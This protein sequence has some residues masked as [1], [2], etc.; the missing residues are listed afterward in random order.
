ME[1]AQKELK[2]ARSLYK[3]KQYTGAEMACRHAIQL[4]GPSLVSR[5]A[6]RLLGMTLIRQNSFD[7][8]IKAVQTNWQ[9]PM[10]MEDDAVLLLAAARSHAKDPYDLGLLRLQA[11]WAPQLTDRF[12]DLIAMPYP[13]PGVEDYRYGEFWALLV[14]ATEPKNDPDEALEDLTQAQRLF[15]RNAVLDYLLG[16]EYLRHKQS[17]K[18]KAA[19]QRAATN[20]KGRLHDLALD[21]LK[22]TA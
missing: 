10:P 5:P 7:E 22:K 3:Q 11:D 2:D 8:A 19:L 20:S 16:K 17:D 15:G 12:G 14:L 13:P 21:L 18:A 9:D 4:L 6:Y 1:E